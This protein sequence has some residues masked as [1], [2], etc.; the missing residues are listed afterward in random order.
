MRVTGLVERVGRDESLAYYRTRPRG[1]QLGAWTSRQSS[2]LSDRAVLEQ[3]LAETTQRFATTAELPLPEHWGGFR[4]VPE[5]LEFW[6][7]RESRLH[8]RIAYRREGERWVVERL[9]P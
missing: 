3:A 5:S 2:V 6:Q 8:D 7:G 9:S 4:V 1:S